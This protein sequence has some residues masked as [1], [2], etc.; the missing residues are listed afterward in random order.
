MYVF[1]NVRLIGKFRAPEKFAEW[2][3]DIASNDEDEE[4]VEFEEV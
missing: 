3:S 2:V 4:A 1:I